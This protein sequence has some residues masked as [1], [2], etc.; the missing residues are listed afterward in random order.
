MPS[1][2]T[3][4][5]D[6]DLEWISA[7]VDN[8]LEA[9]Q[10]SEFEKRLAS[11]ASLRAVVDEIR[12]N[13]A[14][15][16]SLPTYKAPRDYTL[17]P[18]VY[19]KRAALLLRSNQLDF[20]L[21]AFGAIGAAASV[22][23]I[24]LGLFTSS[25]GTSTY[26]PN[27]QNSAA[28]PA[29]VIGYS[30]LSETSPAPMLDTAQSTTSYGTS[31]PQIETDDNAVVGAKPD[32]DDTSMYSG[33]VQN[34]GIESDHVF[35]GSAVDEEAAPAGAAAPPLQSSQ[36]Q[37]EETDAPID[38]F[39]QDQPATES[40]AYDQAPGASTSPPTATLPPSASAAEAM[41]SPIME[42]EPEVTPSTSPSA[43][44]A[45]S[46]TQPIVQEVTPKDSTGDIKPPSENRNTSLLLIGIIL[47]FLSGGIFM[48]G[49]KR[50]QQR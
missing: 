47:L 42:R 32:A 33:Q 13:K 3:P 30:E 10:R 18:A 27:S 12:E 6:R 1:Q 4:S 35:D 49:R 45:P 22:V 50:T 20:F 40:E 31:M 8:M 14:L 7:Y 43:R 15:L 41:E 25:Q 36:P 24:M 34:E 21:R 48:A 17:D 39:E 5:P 11:D 46:P 16:G 28:Q 23:L 38:S 37:G 2:P 29:T 26:T 19:G 9:K 44:F